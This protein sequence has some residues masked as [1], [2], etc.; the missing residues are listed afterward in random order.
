MALVSAA[1]FGTSGVVA[2]S[3]LDTGWTPGAVVT[4][5]IAVAAVLLLPVTL[6][7]LRGRWGLLR[8]QAGVVLGYGA[9]AVAGAQLAYFS[10]IQHLSVGVALLIEYLAPVLIVGYLWARTGRRPGR[11]T[12]AG[13]G[14]SLAGLVLVLDLTGQVRINLVGVLWALMAAIGLAAYFLL[15]D[16]GGDDA[17]RSV[18]PIALAGAGLVVGSVILGVAGASGVLPMAAS[19]DDVRLAGLTVPW[20]AAGLE[21]AIVAGSFAYVLGIVAVRRLGSTVASFIS[22]TEV[23]FAVLFAWLLL[24]QLPMPVQL[25]GG[26][27]I[28]SGVIAVRVGESA[29]TRH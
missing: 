4:M 11:L 29:Q 25:L 24:G 17:D 27:L 2:R 13:V 1:A 8:S 20:W 28:V 22:L 9:L 23:L 10:A 14:L 16:H 7:A 6:V 5:R 18:P 12:A 19:T 26:A 15:S 3:L 21:L